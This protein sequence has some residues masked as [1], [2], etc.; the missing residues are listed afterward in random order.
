M[1][2][3]YYYYTAEL[4]SLAASV[5]TAAF[6]DKRRK[7]IT[8]AHVFKRLGQFDTGIPCATVKIPCGA[9]AKYTNTP[10]YLQ[11]GVCSTELSLERAN[12]S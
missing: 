1:L 9:V 5:I 2:L 4:G 12:R 7:W 6:L 8:W 11:R 3:H 10:I